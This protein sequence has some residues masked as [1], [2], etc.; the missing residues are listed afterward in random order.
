MLVHL[1]FVALLIPMPGAPAEAPSAQPAVVRVAS[2]LGPAADRVIEKVL[3]ERLPDV[4]VTVEGLAAPRLR[5]RLRSAAEESPHVLLGAPVELLTPHDHR[6]RLRAYEPPW[7]ASLPPSCRDRLGYWHA[8]LLEPLVIGYSKAGLQGTFGARALP[9]DYSD[10]GD[11]CWEGEIA[12][13]SPAPY[14]DGAFLFLALLERS[15]RESGELATAIAWLQGL[16]ANLPPRADG[17]PDYAVGSVGC[18][19]RLLDRDRRE[20]LT[21]CRL[22][23]LLEADPDGEL[24]WVCPPSG[25]VAWP[26]CV[27]LLAGA[28]DV[29]CRVIDLVGEGSVLAEL[30]RVMHAVPASRLSAAH[31]LVGLEWRFAVDGDKA[32]LLHPTD[33]LA[34]ARSSSAW[35]GQF[36][37]EVRGRVRRQ[38]A[39]FDAAFEWVALVVI[40]GAVAFAGLKA[41]CRL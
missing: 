24:G 27:V 39:T 5:E 30:G 20:I 38:F 33:Y 14:T 34:L 17:E 31:A 7:A 29:A 32:A 23:S 18:V 2:A 10:L 41:K 3:A 16:D 9:V 26:R 4:I 12:L 35:L 36:E 21:V 13:A 40:A 1:S 37:A 28:P 8:P 22:G 15:Q 11:P 6:E 25:A 19:Q